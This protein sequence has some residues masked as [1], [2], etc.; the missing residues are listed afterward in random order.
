MIPLVLV[1]TFAIA[2]IY[3]NDLK[4]RK[5]KKVYNHLEKFFWG[6]TI[7]SAWWLI[8]LGL[9]TFAIFNASDY[10]APT[11]LYFF[12]D[13]YEWNFHPNFWLKRVNEKRVNNLTLEKKANMAAIKALKKIDKRLEQEK[14]RNSRFWSSNLGYSK[15]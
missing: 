3:L 13:G 7:L 6:L 1:I 4:T 5:K 10:R 12:M 14:N 9:A 11:R 8:I 15:K 2:T